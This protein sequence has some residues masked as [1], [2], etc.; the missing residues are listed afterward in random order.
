[1][2][3]I[4][5]AL[6]KSERERHAGQTPA[7]DEALTRSPSLPRRARRGDETA[8]VIR[9]ALAVSAVFLIA[10]LT[11]WLL[12]RG[13][14]SEGTAATV[15][16]VAIEVSPAAAPEPALVEPAA[17][18]AVPAPAAPMRIDPERLEAPI[19]SADLGPDAASLDELL[20]ETPEA[21]APPPEP[22]PVDALAQPATVVSPSPSPS[23]SP[24]SSVR[25]LKDMPPSFRS[26][27]PAL[28]LQVHVYD[29]NPLRRFVLVNGKKY[30]ETDTLVEGP[31]VVE[32][33]E[34][35]IVL[36]QRGTRVLLETP[37]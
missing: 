9:T 28:S 25:P 33:V 34:N 12:S 26:G 7:I 3:F 11:W 17:E 1:M 18:I 16:E 20:D 27:F 6:Q 15:P 32:I 21:A 10:G 37:G 8:L 13:G 35:G 23:P 24:R 29:A 36:E 4:L 30:R 5:D 31:Q 22:P 19:A 2:S 14:Q